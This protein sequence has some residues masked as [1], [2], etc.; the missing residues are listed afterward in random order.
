MEKLKPGFSVTVFTAP[1]LGLGLLL[2]R[3]PV[4]ATTKVTTMVRRKPEPQRCM[5]PPRARLPGASINVGG[6]KTVSVDA[7]FQSFKVARFQSFKD[8]LSSFDASNT[9]VLSKLRCPLFV[10]SEMSGFVNLP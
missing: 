8:A 1:P 2:P 3:Q 9:G 10:A 6:R 5:N 7:R 4:R